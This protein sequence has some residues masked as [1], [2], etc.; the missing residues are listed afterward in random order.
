MNKV[1][2][3]EKAVSMVESGMSI[4]VGGFMGIG[5]PHKII[6]ALSETGV[7]NLT[8]ICNDTGKPDFGVA[9]MVDKK[10]FKKIIASHI[11]L[12]P[13]TIRQLNEKEIEVEL[14]PQGTL[15]ERIRAQGAGL[16]GVLTGTG[17]GTVVE[18]GKQK[19]EIDGK[20]YLLEKPLKADIAL[21][22]G[23]AADKKGN[24]RFHGSTRTFNPVMAMAAELVILE[25][26][27]L[28]EGPMP[29]DDVVIPHIFI[30]YIVDG[31]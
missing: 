13:E 22:F 29:P 9:K 1:I 23:N 11:G 28:L 8:L 3:V 25:T 16:G 27:E 24:V 2:T 30:D 17:I 5:S 18:D 26:A 21:L 4:M 19:V 20:T 12:N 31:R 6:E 15:A 14:I 10:Q 7:K